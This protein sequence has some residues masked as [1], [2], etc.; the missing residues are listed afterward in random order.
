MNPVYLVLV[1]VIIQKLFFLH[2]AASVLEIFDGSLQV[3]V[4]IFHVVY[5]LSSDL[6]LSL[7]KSGDYAH[8]SCLEGQ[9]GTCDLFVCVVDEIHSTK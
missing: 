6:S 2:L 3:Y 8:E 4:G 9:L 7:A 1:T 5:R